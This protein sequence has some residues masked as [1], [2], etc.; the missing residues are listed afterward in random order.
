VPWAGWFPGFP[1]RLEIT[2]TGGTVTVEDGRIV[3][4][5]LAAGPAAGTG[6]AGT[7]T[8]AAASGEGGVTPAAD[9]A[10]LDVASHAALDVASHAAQLADL[11]AA[12]DAG[13]EPAVSGQS[14][15][16]ALEIVCAVYESSRSGCPVRLGP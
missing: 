13:R 6:T 10:A 5:A 14:G 7:G 12:V 2:G 1:Q 4:R 15:R 11:L 8:A 9:P 3:R 16:D